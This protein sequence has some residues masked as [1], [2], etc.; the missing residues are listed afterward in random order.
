MDEGSNGGQTSGM[1]SMYTQG[2]SPSPFNVGQPLRY[3]THQRLSSTLSGG[4]DIARAGSSSAGLGM[5]WQGSP[6][7]DNR[8]ADEDEDPFLD[9]T[10]PHGVFVHEDGGSIRDWDFGMSESRRGYGEVSSR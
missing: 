2:R 1:S 3:N 9:R 6:F 8:Q 7:H 4:S 5:T 10:P